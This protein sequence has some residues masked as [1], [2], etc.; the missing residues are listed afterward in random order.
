MTINDP[1]DDPHYQVGPDKTKPQFDRSI[2]GVATAK[3]VNDFHTKDDVDSSFE[4]HHHT[5]GTRQDQASSGAHNHDG[6]NSKRLLQGVS[7]SGSR[8]S[9]AALISVIDALEKLG[10]TD[11]TVA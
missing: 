9:G 8:G 11:N 10:A 5:I 4:A 2:P 7:I 1:R 6:K 3:A